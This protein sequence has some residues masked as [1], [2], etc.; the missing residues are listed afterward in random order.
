MKPYSSF[1]I[2][3]ILALSTGLAEASYWAPA[4]PP[5]HHDGGAV[6]GRG[7]DRIEVRAQVR[8]KRLGYYHGPI[9]G[10]FGRGSRAALIRFQRHNG[11]RPTGSLDRWTIRAL[12]L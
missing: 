5:R 12:H 3:G 8:L 9:D 11:L 6:R 7:H 4:P 1:A 10:N 2:A